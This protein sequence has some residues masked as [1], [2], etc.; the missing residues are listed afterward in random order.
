MKRRVEVVVAGPVFEDV[1]EEIELIGM[2]RMLTEET[3]EGV[4]RV[5]M[6]FLQVQVGDEERDWTRGSGR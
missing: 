3:E 1:A 6:G 5:R 4:G 2:R